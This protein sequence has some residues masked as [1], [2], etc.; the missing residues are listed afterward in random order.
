MI[1]QPGGAPLPARSVLGQRNRLERAD[2]VI[3]AGCS[4]EALVK[5]GAEVP[6][7]ALV[8][9]VAIKTPYPADDNDATDAIVPKIAKI[10]ETQVGTGVGTFEASVIVNDDL[11]QPQVVFERFAVDVFWHGGAGVITQR[12][13]FPFGV[14]DAAVVG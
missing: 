11:R 6:V 1:A 14:D 5:S 8:I 9:F 7:I 12:P 3:R 4:E 2:D 10:M 13:H